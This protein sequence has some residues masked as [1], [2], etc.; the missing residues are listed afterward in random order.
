MGASFSQ[1]F[2]SL[3]KC[4]KGGEND[5]ISY[6]T[7]AMQGRAE[8]MTDAVSILLR[9]A[10]PD[11]DDLTSF[12]G[13]YDGHGGAS[14]ALFCAKQLHIELRNHQDY[15]ANLPDAMRS[16]FFRMDE[17]LELSDE[18]K[19]SL[20][21]ATSNNLMQSLRALCCVPKIKET[22]PYVPPQE[23]GSTACVA[24][25]RGH[26]IIVGNVGDSRCVA[27]RNGQA[28]V[29]SANHKPLNQTERNRIQAAGGQ[30]LRDPTAEGKRAGVP[31]INGRLTVS[32]AIGDFAYKHKSGLTRE[33]QMVT[34]EP[35]V[36]SLDITHDV[37][38]LIVA[39]DAIWDTMMTS[40]GVV[41]LVCHYIRNGVNDRAICE[42]LCQRSL[43]SLDNST[44]ILVRFNPLSRLPPPLPKNVPLGALLEE[45]EELEGGEMALLLG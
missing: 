34:C 35:S 26:Q 27:S 10:V 4:T 17:L 2:P 1:P 25:I 33:Q 28:I 42:Q 41:D 29:L 14:V 12:F 5:R 38:F 7:S 37:E 43:K 16:V 3:D 36:R 45:D 6:A 9:A 24:V 8:T 23:T 11:L 20:R 22:D 39:T 18:W 44:V 15:Q 40:Q 32:R 30:V 31:G 19:E 13:V 21:P